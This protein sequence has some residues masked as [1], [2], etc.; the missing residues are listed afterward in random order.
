MSAATVKRPQSRDAAEKLN[1]KAA[2]E[3]RAEN[4]DAKESDW[5]ADTDTLRRGCIAGDFMVGKPQVILS[6]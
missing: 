4:W 2:V 1:V 3:V 5:L 6:G